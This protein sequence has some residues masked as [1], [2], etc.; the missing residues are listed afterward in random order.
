[1]YFRSGKSQRISQREAKTPPM[2]PIIIK[3]SPR[4]E[5]RIKEII[6]KE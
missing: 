1:M 4:E 2:S 3:E 5:E 6:L